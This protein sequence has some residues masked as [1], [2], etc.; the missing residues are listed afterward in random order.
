MHL[1]VHNFI[2]ANVLPILPP[3]YPL[4]LKT[5]AKVDDILYRVDPTGARSNAYN[6]GRHDWVSIQWADELDSLP[7]RILVFLSFLI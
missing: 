2:K 5:S 1:H 6:H 4:Q 7:A 3:A